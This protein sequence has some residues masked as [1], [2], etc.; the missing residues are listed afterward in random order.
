MAIAFLTT[1]A[2]ERKTP[3]L[4]KHQRVILARFLFLVTLDYNQSLAQELTSLKTLMFP[5]IFLQKKNTKKIIYKLNEQ[6]NVINAAAVLFKVK[7]SP[8]PLTN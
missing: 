3:T 5:Q 7:F 8:R 4:K 1:S 2:P 6:N